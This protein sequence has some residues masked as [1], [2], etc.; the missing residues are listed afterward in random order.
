MNDLGDAPS[1][2]EIS[3]PVLAQNLQSTLD[4]LPDATRL[5][6]VVKGDAYGH[7]IENIVPQLIKQNIGHIGISSN[8]EARAVRSAGFQ[9]T[10]LR[11]RSAPPHEMASALG[12]GVEEL[13]G[14]LAAVRS[15]IAAVGRGALPHLHLSLNAAGMSRDGLELSTD[16]GRD[17]LQQIARVVPDKIVGLCTHFPSNTSDD[18]ATSITRFHTDLDW[19]FA[20]TTLRRSDI[21]VHAGSTL[22]LRSG[23]DPK[24]DMMRCGAILYGIKGPRPAFQSAMTLKSRIVSI[25]H[26]PKGCTVGYDRSVQ[27]Q[28]DAVLASVTLGYANG[29][30]SR[31]SNCGAVL[32]RGQTL[33]VMGKV[34]MNT[35][36]V[37]V[38]SLPDAEIGDEVVAF[39]LQGNQK[40]G[41]LAIERVTGSIMA[42]VFTHWG[43]C[44]ARLAIPS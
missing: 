33:P 11:L 23:Q 24:A 43:Q 26:Y 4:L 18:L 15:L 44:N 19:L 42:D 31:F 2:C 29:Y 35:I 27:L 40:I 20:N 34:S 41:S 21:L 13:V 3:L 36:V 30:S 9:G 28:D 25:G 5:C 10:V 1:W 38:S 12:T 6:A 37:D 14:S 32:I 7:G 17:E 39:G 16:R 8:A 22:T